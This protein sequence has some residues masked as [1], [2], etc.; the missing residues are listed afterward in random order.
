MLKRFV[1]SMLGA[2]L[3]LGVAATP[4]L[5]ASSQDYSFVVPRFGG[6]VYSSYK[7]VSAAKNFGTY[8]RYSGGKSLYFQPMY[9][10][11]SAAG[12]AVLISPQGPSATWQRIWYNNSSTSR[13]ICIKIRTTS[14]TPVDVLAQGTWYWNL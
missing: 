14:L 2:L 1:C 11:G 4:A 13:S 5:A 7:V 3:A 9:G 6:A 12:S 10:T 8:H